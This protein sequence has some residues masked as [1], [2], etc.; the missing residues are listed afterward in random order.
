M[1][2][3]R[4]P[5]AGHALGTTGQA[6]RLPRQRQQATQGPLTASLFGNALVNAGSITTMVV[7]FA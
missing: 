3:C 7:A 4:D 1:V 6:S 2:L 5:L